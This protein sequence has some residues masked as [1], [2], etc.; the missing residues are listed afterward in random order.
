MVRKSKISPIVYLI[1]FLVLAWV[2]SQIGWIWFT[3]LVVVG[4]IVFITISAQDPSPNVPSD[5]FGPLFNTSQQASAY[6][7]KLMKSNPTKA[8]RLR[9]QQI[10]RESLKLAT[11]SKKPETAESR[12][13][14]AQQHFLALKTKFRIPKDEREGI[15][16]RYHEAVLEYDTVRFLNEA[17]AYLKKTQKL[18][19][20][21]SKRKYINLARQTIEKGLGN[22]NSD[23]ERLRNFLRKCL[24]NN[25]AG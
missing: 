10:L 1:I 5:E 21:K 18:K 19:T 4:A 25:T 7:A 24:P 8:N 12:M 16:K 3:V 13:E 15:D 6:Y 17:H 2:I 11:T 9:R 20:E 23:K 22:P 14:L